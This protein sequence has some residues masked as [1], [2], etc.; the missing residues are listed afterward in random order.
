[1]KRIHFLILGILLAFAHTSCVINKPVGRTS[2][3]DYNQRQT[4]YN[5][6]YNR[7]ASPLGIGVTVGGT[8]AGAAIGYGLDPV[9]INTSEGANESVPAASAALGAAVGFGVSSFV[10]HVVL[11]QGQ[12]GVPAMNK[13]EWLRKKY[14]RQKVLLRTDRSG[15]TF[16]DRSAEFDF[17]VRDIADVRDYF[18]AF[19]G[20]AVTDKEKVIAKAIPKVGR[21]NLPELLTTL[22]GTSHAREVKEKYLALSSSLDELYEAINRYPSVKAMAEERIMRK[23]QTVSQAEKFVR[24]YPQ[25][26]YKKQV[27]AQVFTK[28]SSKR[29]VSRMKRA[30]GDDFWITKEEF[31][32]LRTTS[33]DR[34][35]YYQAMYLSANTHTETSLKNFFKEYNWIKFSDKGYQVLDYY[36]RLQYPKF[37]N[38]NRLIG[39]VGVFAAGEGRKYG[40]SSAVS[41]RLV[42]DKLNDE[43]GKVSILS[44]RVM[45]SYNPKWEE[46]KRNTTLSAGLVEEK[47]EAFYL[48]YGEISNKSKFDLP[49]KITASGVLY[50]RTDFSAKEGTLSKDLADFLRIL[51]AGDAMDQA[52]TS[53]KKIASRR[54]EY[55][56]PYLP[57]NQRTLYAAKVSFG[58]MTKKS[59]VNIWE[60]YNYTEELLFENVSV[61]KSLYKGRVSRA[62]FDKQK[63]WQA[64]AKNGIPRGN[65]RDR[66]RG[67]EYDP[68]YWR[69]E[70]QRRQEAARWDRLQ[71]EAEED[72]YRIINKNDDTR[73]IVRKNAGEA[74]FISIYSKD[75]EKDEKS[76]YSSVSYYPYSSASDRKIVEFKGE[77]SIFG[78]SSYIEDNGVGIIL[79]ESRP[80]IVTVSYTSKSGEDISA[81]IELDGSS[82][83][84]ITVIPD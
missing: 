62:V 38:G 24:T 49:I 41:K 31:E 47:G 84:V 44:K 15:L 64:L 27:V 18:R 8:A 26:K 36:W 40:T 57:A 61:R 37:K 1:M 46:W 43:L 48:V 69:K 50:L 34:A 25:T 32:K 30:Y 63:K 53:K 35:G 67:I 78:T 29:D 72:E 10:N 21:E 11:K 45:E 82:S 33:S 52:T 19:S 12:K 20:A 56:V 28:N 4:V 13:Q 73:V 55:F 23:T 71:R 83:W 6:S 79:D 5:P 66:W 60:E 17:E 74:G 81:S 9:R 59:G 16:I 2:S 51:G 7:K 68:E 76:Y 75:N 77:S 70:Y 22:P 65:L 42:W 3:P 14:G 39:K 54:Q 80:I 58:N